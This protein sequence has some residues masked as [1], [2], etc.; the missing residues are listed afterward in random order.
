MR[1]GRWIGGQKK[2]KSC[3]RSLWT[4]IKHK[5]VRTWS[6]TLKKN[7][8]LKLK[9]FSKSTIEI[10]FT[11]HS[12]KDVVGKKYFSAVGCL[13]CKE[14]KE[15]TSKCKYI[16]KFYYVIVSCVKPW[17]VH[18][19]IVFNVIISHWPFKLQYGFDHCTRRCFGSYADIGK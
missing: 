13:T 1:Q 2:P 7:Y 9:W 16:Q 8:F 18:P 11:V 4:I 6:F 10:I 12:I 15:N 3:Q 17:F 5:F 14:K 19:K